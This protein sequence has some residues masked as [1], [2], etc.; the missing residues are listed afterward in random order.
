MKQSELSEKTTLQSTELHDSSSDR[1]PDSVLKGLDAGWLTQKRTD[2][3]HDSDR[4]LPLLDG[5]VEHDCSVYKIVFDDGHEYVGV[6]CKR[7]LARMI[8]HFETKPTPAI[9]RHAEDGVGYHFVCLLSGAARPDAA[10]VEKL[11]IAHL[12][13]PLNNVNHKSSETEL[14]RV[15]KL[16]NQM[17]DL[18]GLKVC[19]GCHK[20]LPA[21]DRTFE[22]SK[23]TISRIGPRCKKCKNRKKTRRR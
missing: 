7:I 12:P 22:E 13:K 8:E 6:T 3:P 20:V 17:I 5:E 10:A 2:S 9:V 14:E 16:L 1:I 19:H 15:S 23:R 18:L 11:H 21:N 4:Y